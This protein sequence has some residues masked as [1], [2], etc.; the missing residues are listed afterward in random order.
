MGTD[1][2]RRLRAPA[3]TTAALAGAV[4]ALRLRDPHVGG[5]W[6]VCPSAELGVWCPLCGG[7]RAVNDLTHLRLADAASSN[8]LLLL[9]GPVLVAVLAGWW[10]RAWADRPYRPDERRVWLTCGL[11]L[12]SAVAFG[13]L[14]NLPAGAWF[15]P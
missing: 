14:R 1:D 8:L 9:W 4:L 15:A 6:G 13:V 3:L 2:V 7:L 10:W 5:S 11:L 12:V